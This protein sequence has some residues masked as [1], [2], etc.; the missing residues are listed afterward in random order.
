MGRLGDREEPTAQR[1]ERGDPLG[2][3]EVL[4]RALLVGK[5]AGVVGAPAT[6][7]GSRWRR[8]GHLARVVVGASER[9]PGPA[10][11]RRAGRPRI[12]E[13]PLSPRP[14][15]PILRDV[16]RWFIASPWRPPIARSSTSPIPA[17]R[18]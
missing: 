9:E 8:R 15:D 5:G 6:Q 3:R 11:D 4:V 13:H 1:S 16:A 14:V 17:W 18:R 2:R 7:A 10:G 12:A